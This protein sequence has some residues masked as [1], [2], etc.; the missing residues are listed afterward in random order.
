MSRLGNLPQPTGAARYA[1]PNAR[2]P[3]D[4]ATPRNHDTAAPETRRV[5]QVTLRLSPRAKA[6]VEHLY[7]L[8]E[9]VRRPVPTKAGVRMNRPSANAIIEELI[10]AFDVERADKLFADAK[11]SAIDSE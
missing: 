7:R 1:A 2:T 5:D 11:S 6:K 10:L 8:L 9:H 3:H 4:T